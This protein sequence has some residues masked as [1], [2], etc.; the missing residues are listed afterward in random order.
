M[1]YIIINI[2]QTY[3]SPMKTNDLKNQKY[4]KK[5]NGEDGKGVN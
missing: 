4:C 2:Q 5:L 3:K 1:I